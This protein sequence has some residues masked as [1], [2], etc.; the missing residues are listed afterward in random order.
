MNSFNVTFNTTQVNVTDNYITPN[1]TGVTINNRN[2][3]LYIGPANTVYITGTSANI[4]LTNITYIPILQ[5]ATVNICSPVDLT[6]SSTT[7]TTINQTTDQTTTTVVSQG[8][9]TTTTIVTTTVPTTTVQQTTTSTTTSQSSS[10]S[11]APGFGLNSIISFV[12]SPVGIGSGA[13]ILIIIAAFAVVYFVRHRMPPPLTPPPTSQQG[14]IKVDKWTIE[15]P[16]Q[17]PAAPPQQTSHT[18][19]PEVPEQ[20]PDEPDNPTEQK[21]GQS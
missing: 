11:L 1:Y 4:L 21:P 16:V 10:N 3:N 5:T 20:Q 6:V 14:E 8:G 2:Y 17:H 13:V 18:P 7:T 9:S 12:K 19:K 15:P